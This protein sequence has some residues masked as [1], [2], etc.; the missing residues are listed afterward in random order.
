MALS[1]HGSTGESDLSPKSPQSYGEQREARGLGVTE[2]A[3]GLELGPG[4][5]VYGK[6][7]FLSESQ[8]AGAGAADGLQ[9]SKGLAWGGLEVVRAPD[10][11]GDMVVMG[12]KS[13]GWQCCVS[14]LR[15][16]CPRGEGE[17]FRLGAA[18]GGKVPASL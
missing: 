12:R 13:P 11:P 10:L 14:D 17:S 6:R 1:G 15:L 5:L 4:N 16:R 2:G 3:M 7:G 9:R 18:V 8:P